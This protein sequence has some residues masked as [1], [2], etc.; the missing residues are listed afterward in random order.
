MTFGI[1]LHPKASRNPE[2]EL[3]GTGLKFIL[4]LWVSM[5]RDPSLEE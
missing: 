3:R 5:A 2:M 1:T 4:M